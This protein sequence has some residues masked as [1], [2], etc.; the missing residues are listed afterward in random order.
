MGIKNRGFASMSKS[1]RRR[2][3]VMGGKASG[4]NFKHD[5][6]RASEAGKKGSAAQPLE[7]KQLGGRTSKRGVRKNG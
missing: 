6:R 4:G 1:E 7:A 2:I 5:P 3:A